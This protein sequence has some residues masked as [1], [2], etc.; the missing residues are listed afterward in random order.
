MEQNKSKQGKAPMI[1]GIIFLIMAL[2][3]IKSVFSSIANME[4]MYLFSLLFDVISIIAYVIMGIALLKNKKQKPI[5]IG[6]V[7]LAVVSVYWLLW[8]LVSNSYALIFVG[9]D[10]QFNGICAI[11]ALL[12]TV[13][14]FYFAIL[15]GASLK[16]ENAKKM[17]LV[18]KQWF[19]PAGVYLLAEIVAVILLFVMPNWNGSYNPFWGMNLIYLVLIVGSFA[20]TLVGSIDANEVSDYLQEK[21]KTMNESAGNFIERHPWVMS[22]FFL[23]LL[24]CYESIIGFE[25]NI[26]SWILLILTI[27]MLWNW[28][29][30]LTPT[31][32]KIGLVVL[33][34]II[35]IVLC[36]TVANELQGS[37]YDQLTE[38]EKEYYKENGDTIH[39]MNEWVNENQ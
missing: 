20:L 38:E 6:A 1:A 7:L 27:G 22:I 32:K 10:I 12:E 18:K 35:G 36:M 9:G 4:S 25:W 16:K 14:Y 19:V 15:V 34:I 2:L 23:I 24:G 37:K 8:G 39:D 28:I 17:L 11:P 5:F 30:D 3:Y 31:K 13:A 26:I 21:N 29:T 33:A